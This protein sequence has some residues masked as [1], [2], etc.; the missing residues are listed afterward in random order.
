M[1]VTCEVQ[2]LL[3]K[4]RVRAV[5][6]SD[7]DGLMR[8][9]EV[10][11]TGAPISVPVGGSTLGRIFNVLGEPVDNLG[12]VD[13]HT[14]SPIHRSAPA[15]IQLDTKFSIFETGMKVVD[16]LA[17]VEEK[18]GEEAFKDRISFFQR[19]TGFT[20]A[21]QTGIGQLNHKYSIKNFSVL[22][23]LAGAGYRVRAPLMSTQSKPW[24]RLK[25]AVGK[26]YGSTKLPLE[27]WIGRGKPLNPYLKGRKV[28]YL[29]KELKPKE[30][31]LFPEQLVFDG[32]REILE[33]TVVYQW[34]RQ[35][36]TWLSWYHTISSN[37]D[38]SLDQFFDAPIC[39]TSWKRQDFDSNIY[40]FGILWK[41]YDMRVAWSLQTC[42]SYV[43]DDKTVVTFDP[44]ILG[45]LS[46]HDFMMAPVD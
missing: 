13:T 7:T 17:S 10:I 21:V 32:E 6:M 14:T 23:R 39:A 19:K 3:G 42:P 16:L 30:V 46:G 33:R 38:P 27:W 29:L 34:M 15:F 36:L 18:S 43:L 1:N 20:E 4:N 45:G 41:V 5:A 37:P 31:R 2:Q 40:K 25:A 28:F 26:P 24:E 8:G 11:D 44:W 9:M 12:P 22:Q 35:W